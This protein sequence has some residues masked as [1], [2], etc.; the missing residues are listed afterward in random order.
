MKE[1]QHCHCSVQHA[2]MGQQPDTIKYRC[3][4][5]V[6]FTAR[7]HMHHRCCSTWWFSDVA[8]DKSWKPARAQVSLPFPATE[9]SWAWRTLLASLFYPAH[10]QDGRPHFPAYF[11]RLNSTNL[12]LCTTEAK[13]SV[14]LW[15]ALNARRS[16]SFPPY[17]SK[18]PYC[19]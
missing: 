17:C 13:L 7:L 14:V 12:S 16:C 9:H 19:S 11:F 6:G 18:S 4:H 2:Q 8:L 3:A 5:S 1:A 15:I 10:L